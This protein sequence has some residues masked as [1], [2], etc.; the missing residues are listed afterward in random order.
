MMQGGGIIPPNMLHDDML[1]NTSKMVGLDKAMPDFKGA[2]LA[3]VKR[4][5]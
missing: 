1:N 5:A 4:T 3:I 2:G